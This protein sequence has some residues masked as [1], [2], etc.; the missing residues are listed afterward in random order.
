MVLHAFDVR[1]PFQSMVEGLIRK[2]ATVTNSWN[3]SELIFYKNVQSTEKS[4]FGE[5]RNSFVSQKPWSSVSDFASDL[6]C[7]LEK[8]L[9]ICL[10][11]S[12]CDVWHPDLNTSISLSLHL[13]IQIEILSSWCCFCGFPCVSGRIS[14][15]SVWQIVLAFFSLSVVSSCGK[16]SEDYQHLNDLFFI[17]KPK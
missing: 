3:N 12:D 4:A 14:H 1:V 5:G 10:Y 16:S 11:S 15:N 17:L 6:M 2:V 13:N 7:D 8:S 9:R